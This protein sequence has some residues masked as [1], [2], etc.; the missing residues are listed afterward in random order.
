MTASFVWNELVAADQEACGDF[1]S[2]LLGWSRK[3]KIEFGQSLEILANVGV[4]AGIIFLAIEISQNTAVVE[5]E[6]S[7]NRTDTA[8]SEAQSIYNSDHLPAIL[9]ALRNG[10][11]ITD[12]DQERIYHWARSFNRNMDNQL[13]LY[14]QGMLDE[15][16]IRSMEFAIQDVIG[17]S[18]VTRELWERSKLQYSDDYIQ[19]VDKVLVSNPE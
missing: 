10:E 13:R 15:N 3:E 12:V 2:N 7:Q 4:L 9:T 8:M 17:F 19:I 18:P 11:S 16:V 1:Y 5:A 14:R 6:M